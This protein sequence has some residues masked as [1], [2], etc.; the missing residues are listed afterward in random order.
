MCGPAAVMVGVGVASSLFQF[1]QQREAAEAANE[2]AAIQHKVEVDRAKAE[3]QDRQNQL[4]QEALEESQRIG[5][6]RQQLAL[7]ALQEQSSAKVAAA[8]GG[9]G[10]VSKIR[11]FLTADIQ[12]DLARSDIEKNVTN[13]QFN[14]Q[15]RARGI[16]TAKQTRVDNA[17][18]TRQA[19][20]RRKPGMG[21]L[22]VGIAGNPLVQGGVAK[23]FA[24]QK[25]TN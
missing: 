23:G 3:A 22:A 21:D 14:L 12:G 17:F 13:A 15:Q 10:G 19:N 24:S 16:Q 25:K 7:Q 11:S 5:Q 2:A 1:Q 6:Q 20:T 18:L 9:L 4:S 8:E